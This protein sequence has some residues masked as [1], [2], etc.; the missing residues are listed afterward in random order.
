MESE[1]SSPRRADDNVTR[2]ADKIGRA[3]LQR[4]GCAHSSVDM[5]NLWLSD[6]CLDFERAVF[7]QSV[8]H[9]LHIVRSVEPL[10]IVA[11]L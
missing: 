11:S 10:S 2:G 1:E 3:A 8:S 6:L 5:V 7:P 9:H 4:W